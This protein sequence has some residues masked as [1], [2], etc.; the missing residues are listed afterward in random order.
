MP[1]G[2]GSGVDPDEAQNS[3]AEN[4]NSDR[5]LNG[6]NG[7]QGINAAQEEGRYASGV[8]SFLGVDEDDIDDDAAD[9]WDVT[10]D[11]VQDYEDNTGEEEAADWLSSY[12]GYYQNE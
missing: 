2:R 8:A 3:W 5:F 9:S 1:R 7:D 4:T 11:D 12:A 10:E 6:K